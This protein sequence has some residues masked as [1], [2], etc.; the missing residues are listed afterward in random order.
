VRRTKPLVKVAT[1]LMADPDAKFYGYP[2]SRATGIRS[3]VIYP[4]LTRLLDAGWLTDGWEEPGAINEKRPP[5]RYY[6]LTPA[7]RDALRGLLNDKED[8]T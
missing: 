6:T 2:L 1:E 3:G 4:L 8:R 5:R 7:G